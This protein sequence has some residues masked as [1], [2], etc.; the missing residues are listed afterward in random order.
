MS[1]NTHLTVKTNAL[2]I[3]EAQKISY[4]L[5]DYRFTH[6]VS[7][8]DVAE[9]LNEEPRRVFKTL[10]TIGKSGTHYVFIVSVDRELDLKKAA[11]FVQ[12]K[13]IMMVKERELLPLTGYVHGGCSPI[14]M[15]KYFRTVLDQ[16]ALTYPT[17]YLSAGKIGL[18]I[19]L[20]AADLAKVIK[21]ETADIAGTY[22]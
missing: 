1:L 2:R 16:S 17:I 10:V 12:E 18:Q 5:H 21:L 20:K 7:G 13:N 8:S 19:E 14:G 11:A 4:S 6:K 3:L 15:K 9:V 22:R